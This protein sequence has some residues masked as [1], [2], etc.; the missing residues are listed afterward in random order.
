MIKKLEQNKGAAASH[1]FLCSDQMKPLRRN[2]K[3]MKSRFIELT[4]VVRLIATAVILQ[5]VLGVAVAPV[6]G[7]A[8]FA[9]GW[10]RK[11]AVTHVSKILACLPLRDLVVLEI[12]DNLHSL[13]R[14]PVFVVHPKGVGLNCT[15]CKCSIRITE[16][17]R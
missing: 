3:S 2:R 9:M 13:R 15:C 16:Q 7:G 12:L 14:F 17:K 8:L 6:L 1:R 11:V 10:R 5:H 4:F